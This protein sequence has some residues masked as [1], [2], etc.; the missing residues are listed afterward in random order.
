MATEEGPVT[1]HSKFSQGE[2]G[3]ADFANVL[4]KF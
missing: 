2:E 1:E 3:Y 4:I